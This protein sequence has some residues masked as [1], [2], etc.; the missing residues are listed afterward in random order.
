M[1]HLTLNEFGDCIFEYFPKIMRKIAIHEN[2]YVTKGKITLPQLMALQI[3]SQKSEYQMNELVESLNVSFSTATGMVNR[4][5]KS[6]LVSRRHGVKD[7]RA[8]MVAI[9]K[10]GGRIVNEVYAQKR[11]G[12]I[13]LFKRLSAQERSTYIEII[14]KLV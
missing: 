12:M 11:K 9:T 1:K 13:Q 14:R 8:V 4:L 5:I 6:G 2:N 3:L 10:K 7:R